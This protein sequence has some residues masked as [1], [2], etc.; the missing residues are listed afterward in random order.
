MTLTIRR[1][2]SVRR[3]SRTHRR[4]AHGAQPG[5]LQTRRAPEQISR[6]GGGSATETAHI[7]LPV[8]ELAHHRPRQEPLPEITQRLVRQ[9]QTDVAPDLPSEHARVFGVGFP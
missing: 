5:T 8:P 9:L 1:E 7:A 6:G 4:R 2:P 3:R